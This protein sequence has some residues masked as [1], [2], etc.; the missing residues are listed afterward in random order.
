MGASLIIERQT[1]SQH[2]NHLFCS[3][4]AVLSVLKENITDYQHP[5]IVYSLQTKIFKLQIYHKLIIISENGVFQIF[6]RTWSDFDCWA[7][8]HST[9]KTGTDNFL[10]I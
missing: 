1:D 6:S 5:R 7:S 8:V 4:L 10:R 9:G 2:Y 3:I